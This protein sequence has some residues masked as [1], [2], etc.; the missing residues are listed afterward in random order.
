MQTSA[1]RPRQ[2]S[3][4]PLWAARIQ[5]FAKKKNSQRQLPSKGVQFL[6]F[7]TEVLQVDPDLVHA[8]RLRS[9]DD[10]RAATVVV[11]PT[12]LCQTLLAL[13]RDLADADLVADHLDRLLA[14]DGLTEDTQR[15]GEML[16]RPRAVTD[17]DM[18]KGYSRRHIS[19]G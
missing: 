17:G 15:K 8:A 6:L 5:I 4:R 16:P 12:E 7:L 1:R 19:A 14:G 3:V 11:E 18:E 10:H 13:R 9:A 2:Q